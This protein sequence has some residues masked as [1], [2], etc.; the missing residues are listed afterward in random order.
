MLHLL[1]FIFNMHL[2]PFHICT[3]TKQSKSSA[4]MGHPCD[5]LCRYGVRAE[6]WACVCECVR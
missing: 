4:E 1:V 5:F 3:E 6:W 2:F